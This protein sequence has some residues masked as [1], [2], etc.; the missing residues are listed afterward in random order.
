MKKKR[1]VLGILSLVLILTCACSYGQQQVTK[2]AYD[3]DLDAVGIGLITYLSE[4][5]YEELVSNIEQSKDMEKAGTAEFYE[6]IWTGL[7]ANYGAFSNFA[8]T[9]NVLSGGYEVYSYEVFFTTYSINMNI[10]VTS[11]GVLS[12]LN[13]QEKNAISIDGKGSL[14][15]ELLTIGE[16][17]LLEGELVVPEGK[18]TMPLVILVHG[19]GASNRD[20]SINSIKPFYDI[21]EQLENLGIATYRY[22]KRTY[23]YGAD[24]DVDTFTVYEESIEDAVYA[25]EML[26]ADPRFA[27]NV[28]ILGHSL[29]GHVL[30][31]IAEQTVDAKGYIFLAANYSPLTDLIAYQVKYI[32]EVDG[33]YTSAEKVEVEGIV[34][35]CKD[36]AELDGTEEGIYLGAASVYWKDLNDYDPGQAL[37]TIEKP[38]L[39]LQGD[40]DYQVVESELDLWLL[41][42]KE[43]YTTSYVFEGLGHL[44]TPAGD[45]P[46]PS[47]YD[48][49][50]TF[51]SEVTD[52][53][54]AWILEK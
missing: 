4:G 22:D 21:A 47:D 31:R 26:D 2:S 20:E 32:A 51:S 42:A 16:E 36:V 45:P 53:M 28:Y 17:F 1:T 15:G 11:E 46:A 33:D 52:T 7:E 14:G 37:A 6:E 54:A 12:G 38:M 29:G 27:G 39:F 50:Y 23:T 10:V 41:F 13:Y 9:S 3:K 8:Y 48:G 44:F 40:G 49:N 35:L 24:I 43:E 19:S 18:D 34:D 25:Y 30:P 5:K